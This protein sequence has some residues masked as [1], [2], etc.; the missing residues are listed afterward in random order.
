[1]VHSGRVESRLFSSLSAR[2]CIC[3]SF[4]F[5]WYNSHATI[6]TLKVYGWNGFS[7]QEYSEACKYPKTNF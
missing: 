6:H 3:N 7:V 5:F 1:M 4:F 2:A